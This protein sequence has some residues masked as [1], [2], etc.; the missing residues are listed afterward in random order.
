MFRVIHKLYEVTKYT[1]KPNKKAVLNTK[2]IE[3]NFVLVNKNSE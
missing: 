1:K 3:F 2:V